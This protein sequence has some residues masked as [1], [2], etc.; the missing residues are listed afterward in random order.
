M[1]NIVTAKGIETT[2]KESGGS[3][4]EASE[5]R[6]RPIKI[7]NVC[8]YANY[9]SVPYGSTSVSMLSGCS[10]EDDM[11]DDEY[12]VFGIEMDCPLWKAL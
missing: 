8:A 10:R 11:T 4:S 2:R 7:C 9:D 6:S 1:K 12:E 3:L 5:K